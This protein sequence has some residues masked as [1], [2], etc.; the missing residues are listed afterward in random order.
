MA[1]KHL[2][3]E[4]THLEVFIAQIRTHVTSVIFTVL[5]I[6]LIQLCNSTIRDFFQSSA[7]TYFYT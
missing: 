7:Y 3:K 1:T 4:V 6:Q 5:Y 2:N